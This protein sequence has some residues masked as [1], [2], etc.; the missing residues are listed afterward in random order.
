MTTL[1]KIVKELREAADADPFDPLTGKLPSPVHGR[2]FAMRIG[3]GN[4]SVRLRVQ[5]TKTYLGGRY[6]YQL[7]I[8]CPKGFP[9]NIPVDIISCVKRAFFNGEES[10]SIPSPL[11]NTIQF[12]KVIK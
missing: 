6:A 4:Q 9:S 10:T 5:F 1:E 3:D 2:N 11:G 12:I 8:G 7:S